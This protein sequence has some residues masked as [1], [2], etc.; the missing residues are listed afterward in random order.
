MVNG[1]MPLQ[2]FLSLSLATSFEDGGI[3]PYPSLVWLLLWNWGDFFF[4]M[5]HF[6]D[7]KRCK[8][9]ETV[10]M[11]I[12]STCTIWRSYLLVPLLT[13]FK[14]SFSAPQSP[15]LLL[16]SL[17]SSLPIPIKL[18]HFQSS[19]CLLSFPFPSSPFFSDLTSYYALL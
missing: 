2:D 14:S 17:L 11:R 12:N 13:S 3:K 5:C 19:F 15:F 16:L 6:V 8:G 4:L 9:R 10:M 1:A 18:G 7:F